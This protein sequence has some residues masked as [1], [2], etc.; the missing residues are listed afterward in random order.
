MVCLQM[1]KNGLTEISLIYVALN[2]N[3]SSGGFLTMQ[4]MQQ[5]KRTASQP[6][7]FK[8]PRGFAISHNPKL[9]SNEDETL[10]LINKVIVPSV[11]RKRK[12][13]KKLPIYLRCVYC[14]A[15]KNRRF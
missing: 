7:G 11:E 10:T 2:L 15:R 13:L 6:R 12:K 8:F 4:V 1:I 3:A 9:Y 5:G 14:E